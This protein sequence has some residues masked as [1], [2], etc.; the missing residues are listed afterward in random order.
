MG[1]LTLLLNLFDFVVFWEK[2]VIMM[3][4]MGAGLIYL[5]KHNYDKHIHKHGDD[6]NHHR[7]D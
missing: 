4:F 6:Y 3:P 2:F 1:Y 7:K 5:M